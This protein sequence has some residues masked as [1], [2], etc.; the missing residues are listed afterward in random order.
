MKGW[1][2]QLRDGRLE[3]HIT[4]GKASLHVIGE[5]LA[6]NSMEWAF[7][8]RHGGQPEAVQ[9]VAP[10]AL[11]RRKQRQGPIPGQMELM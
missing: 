1:Q 3:A 9:W 8:S 10:G 5:P 6:V 7:C 11:S 4:T 2:R